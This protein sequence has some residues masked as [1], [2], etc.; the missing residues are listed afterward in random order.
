MIVQR[1]IDNGQSL[2][3]SSQKRKPNQKK[4]PI[5]LA[6]WPTPPRFARLRRLKSGR[7]T[8]DRYRLRRKQFALRANA[9]FSHSFYT[10]I[11][12]AESILFSHFKLFLHAISLT[13]RFFI[14]LIHPLATFSYQLYYRSIVCPTHLTSQRRTTKPARSAYAAV[15]MPPRSFCC[16]F[17]TSSLFVYFHRRQASA[18]IITHQQPHT[19]YVQCT[20][21]VGCTQQ[22]IDS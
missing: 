21:S 19:S 12:S 17:F 8:G 4:S 16:R 15:I 11:S 13:N 5:F 2:S 22:A 18:S 1:P 7:P 20:Y 6:G 10:H 14:H 3:R 9:P